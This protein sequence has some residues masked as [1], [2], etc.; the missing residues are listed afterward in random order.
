MHVKKI[1]FESNTNIGLFAYAN[2]EYCLVGEQTS[3]RDI[4]AI[5]QILK[6]P[7]H[8]LNIAG[9]NL[10]GVFLVEQLNEHHTYD[11]FLL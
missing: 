2:D 1:A 6:V 10:L 5:E 8:K 9:T 11:V 3:E 7:I 4:E